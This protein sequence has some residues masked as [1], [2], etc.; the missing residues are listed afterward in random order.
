MEKPDTISVTVGHREEVEADKVDIHVTI[1]G[2]SLVTGTAALKKAKEVSQLV[3]ALA[4]VG[5]KEQDV[6]LKSIHAESSS[7]ILGKSTSA[8]YRLRV[9]CD[10]LEKLADVLGV[11]T[12]QKNA[13]LDLLGWR[14][15]D[16]KKLKAEWLQ[17][18]LA[19]AKEKANA[20]ASSLGVK[21]LGV[22]ALSEKWLDSEQ[23]DRPF[24]NEQR[25]E[26]VMAKA[27]ARAERI[28]LGFPLSHS[29][30]IELQLETQFR[31]SELSA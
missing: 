27:M 30:W 29:K 1:K 23:P 15:P 9:R 11:I 3:S 6:A 8:T 19:E 4:E 10:D 20:I 21:L 26:A 16:D 12:S 31:V 25:M 5:L 28:D 14:Y 17:S 13:K 18:C 22:H 24:L 7:G 2:S